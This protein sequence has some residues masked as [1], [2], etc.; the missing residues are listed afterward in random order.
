MNNHLFQKVLDQNVF[1][2]EICFF[3]MIKLVYVQKLD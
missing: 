2:V 1:D 3:Y